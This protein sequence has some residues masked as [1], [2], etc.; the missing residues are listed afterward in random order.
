MIANSYALRLAI[1]M[2]GTIA[3]GVSSASAQHN[4]ECIFPGDCLRHTV[5]GIS[6][7]WGK[8]ESSS[9]WRERFVHAT[10]D[11][12]DRMWKER[13]KPMG[14]RILDAYR[15]S[16]SQRKKCDEI[17]EAFWVD[18]RREVESEMLD[19]GRKLRAQVR[20]RARVYAETGH[21]AQD[22]VPGAA[23][24]WE[25]L[26]P[27][28]DDP[29]LR[30]MMK[31]L[32]AMREAHPIDWSDLADRIED[33]LPPEQA[34][35]GRERL[36][37]RYPFTISK[38]HGEKLENRETANVG[39]GAGAG[40]ADVDRWQMYVAVF[41]NR[42]RLTRAQSDA[43]ASVLQEVRTRADQLFHGMQDEVARYEAD[44][45]QA[46]ASRR[47]EVYQLDLDDLFEGF[48]S[49]LHSLLTSAQQQNPNAP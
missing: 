2:S 37:E 20:E 10:P 19:E 22:G 39:A 4:E 35:R 13:G 49:R 24:A 47:R 33:A 21:A 8:C 3:F 17:S 48:T 16:G 6:G 1:A 34:Q 25:A 28:K 31:K 5:F 15:L 27:I 32:D 9:A 46:E 29:Q 26:P 30:G 40:V 45:L 41:T 12:R 14:A 18:R 7:V 23:K 38:Q 43:T 42:Y 11:E 44:G 36:A